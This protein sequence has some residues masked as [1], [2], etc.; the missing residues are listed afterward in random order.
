MWGRLALITLTRLSPVLHI[1]PHH[2][3]TSHTHVIKLSHTLFSHLP[4]PRPTHHTTSRT[5]W[6]HACDKVITY[7]VLSP[8]C[9]HIM[10]TQAT[11]HRSLPHHTWEA[12]HTRYQAL[13]PKL[14]P[15][16]RQSA[17]QACGYLPSCHSMPMCHYTSPLFDVA[18][19]YTIQRCNSWQISH[20]STAGHES[21]HII[22]WYS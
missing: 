10:R 4:V 12:S 14:I 9:P 13:G 11:P 7:L 20:V 6:P 16:Y 1:T 8:A 3:H 18:A 21:P 17:C 15:V 5:H 22:S 2:A 19:A